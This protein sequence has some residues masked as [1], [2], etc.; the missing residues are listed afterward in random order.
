[1]RARLLVALILGSVVGAV[2]FP[3]VPEDS[4]EL[5]VFAL[6]AIAILL[7]WVAIFENKAVRYAGLQMWGGFLRPEWRQWIAPAR[8]SWSVPVLLFVVGMV[9]GGCARVL[10]LPEA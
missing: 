1:M 10:L 2:A 6:V 4:F 3:F 9:A 5:T 8:T 7:G